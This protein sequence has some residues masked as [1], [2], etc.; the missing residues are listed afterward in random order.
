MPPVM[1]E[2][3]A[4]IRNAVPDVEVAWLGEG[5]HRTS[6]AERWHV[7]MMD[8]AGAAGVAAA[9][10]VT[11]ETIG[12]WVDQ[13]VD[14]LRNDGAHLSHRGNT[15]LAEGWLPKLGLA[16]Q[17]PADLDGDGLV[18]ILD[19]LLLLAAW[20]PC[21]VPPDPCPADIDGDGVVGIADFLYL[22]GVWGSGG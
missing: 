9:T 15:R 16:T 22:L 7:Y 6:T 17:I 11:D 3:L 2:F 4:E 18:G 10:M 13:S 1:N 8:E 12:T 20:G 5:V 19:F 14:G 21:P